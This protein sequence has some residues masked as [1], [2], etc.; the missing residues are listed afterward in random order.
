MNLRSK[1]T[2]VRKDEGSLSEE[3]TGEEF[4]EGEANLVVG[5]AVTGEEEICQGGG[6]DK[7]GIDPRV[8]DHLFLEEDVQSGGGGLL[9]GQ[10]VQ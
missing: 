6:E 3:D 4:Q 7:V 1:V 10:D 8:A 5:E 9:L 2:V